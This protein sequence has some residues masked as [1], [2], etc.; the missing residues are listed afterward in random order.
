MNTKCP[1]CAS[2]LDVSGFTTGQD[3]ACPICSQSFT[4]PLL[5]MDSGKSPTP[6]IPQK[7]MRR[8]RTRQASR[9]TQRKYPNLVK[10]VAKMKTNILVSALIS[11]AAIIFVTVWIL[12]RI[13][14]I[15]PILGGSSF[16]G[17]FPALTTVLSCLMALSAVHWFYISRMAYIELM[18]VW[19][20]TEANTRR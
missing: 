20:D 6:P 4:V 12:V 7:Q 19:M 17:F 1:H 8:R 10:F 15:M 18:T 3:L 5:E 14:D 16:S 9:V 2:L 11:A 13:Q